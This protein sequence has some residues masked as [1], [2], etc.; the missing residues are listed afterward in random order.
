MIAGMRMPIA[1]VVAACMA[2]AAILHALTSALETECSDRGGRLVPVGGGVV[3]ID[4]EGRV[5][6]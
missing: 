5:L 6:P 2:I 3:C 4:Q 1:L